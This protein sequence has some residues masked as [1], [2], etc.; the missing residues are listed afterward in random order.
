MAE[1][2]G[3]PNIRL[4]DSLVQVILTLSD[5]E[6][7]LFEQ[8]IQQVRQPVMKIDQFFQ[9]MEEVEPGPTQPS[10]QAISEVVREVREEL[11]SN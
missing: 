10:L 3:T 1:P 9:D 4:I 2:A 5:E 7:A 11:W 8:K 6:Q